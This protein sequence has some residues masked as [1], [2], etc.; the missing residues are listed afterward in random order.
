MCACTRDDEGNNFCF[1]LRAQ[2]IK[3]KKLSTDGWVGLLKSDFPHVPP[4][5]VRRGNKKRRK[6]NENF[7]K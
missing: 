2:K 3:K 1:V 7:D 4:S 6:K 5:L